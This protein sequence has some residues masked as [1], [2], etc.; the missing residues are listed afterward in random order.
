[1]KCFAAVGDLNMNQRQCLEAS[2]VKLF[3]LLQPHEGFL[4]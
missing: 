2:L 3:S 1:M 4:N